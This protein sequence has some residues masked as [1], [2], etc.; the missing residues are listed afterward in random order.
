ML[1]L[2]K[3]WLVIP[4]ADR[5][6]YLPEIFKSSGVDERRI[7]LIRTTIGE[8]IAGAHNIWVQGDLNI[9]TWWNTGIKF[10]QKSGARYVAVLNDDA[11]LNPGDLEE[12]LRKMV[13]EGTT[14]AV[15]VDKGEAGW[16]HCWILDTS[17][18][19]FPDEKFFWW[20]GD[21]DLEIRAVKRSGVSY[22]SLPIINKHPNELTI[23]NARLLYLTKKDINTFRR[24]YP[25]R[26]FK[27][28]QINL[29]KKLKLLIKF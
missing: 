12:L 10:A 24:K 6:N 5:H 27:E 9:H 14:L 25:L 16:G 2:P 20:C 19:V 4:T 8:S 26:A 13:A 28:L 29:V 1:G 7:I 23:S 21:H 15:P 18:G 11:V 17:H 3:L 22:L